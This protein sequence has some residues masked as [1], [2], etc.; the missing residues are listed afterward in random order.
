MMPEHKTTKS[1]RH[2]SIKLIDKLGTSENSKGIN[3]SN[4]CAQTSMTNIDILIKYNPLSWWFHGLFRWRLRI[5]SVTGTT[6]A[7]S[8]REIIEAVLKQ[9]LNGHQLFKWD[10]SALL[11]GRSTMC[12]LGTGFEVLL[13]K[14][15]EFC[16][17]T[18]ISIAG[19]I[20]SIIGYCK[21]KE[22]EMRQMSFKFQVYRWFNRNLS[23]RNYQHILSDYSVKINVR[24]QI[25]SKTQSNKNSEQGGEAYWHGVF[26]SIKQ[27]CTT[28]VLTRT[29][30]FEEKA[31]LHAFN[32]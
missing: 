21:T 9:I 12:Q 4:K 25:S 16:Q 1:D 30:H 19:R 29:P 7:S 28:V 15:C 20:P 5:E 26:K 10:T 18:Y 2:I 32:F 6:P 23:L 11:F 3:T 8:G 17:D 14:K 31:C 22:A 13:A 27:G 24:K